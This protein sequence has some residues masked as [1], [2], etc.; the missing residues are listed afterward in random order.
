MELVFGDNI[1]LISDTTVV[2][3]GIQDVEVI[4]RIESQGFWSIGCLIIS[5]VIIFIISNTMGYQLKLQ[6]LVLL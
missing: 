2:S 3:S 6:M 5:A 1:G 4:D